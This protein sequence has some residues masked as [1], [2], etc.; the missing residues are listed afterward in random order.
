MQ[1]KAFANRLLSGS[2]SISSRNVKTITEQVADSNSV[3]KEGFK[4]LVLAAIDDESLDMKA[5]L[6]KI[7]EILRA[8]EKL[9]GIKS[10]P[11][12]VPAP[13]G[14]P[15]K[16]MQAESRRSWGPVQHGLESRDFAS[17]LLFN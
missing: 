8:Q 10:D 3:M 16:T 1:S 11:M 12:P 4:Q 2:R 17:R 6:K 15:L 14:T 9:M 5:T 13:A 7:G